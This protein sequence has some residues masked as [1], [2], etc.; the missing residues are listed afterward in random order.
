M[1]YPGEGHAWAD[2]LN[3]RARVMRD[4]QRDRGMTPAQIVQGLA[5]DETQVRLILM[6]VADNPKEFPEDP[7]PTKKRKAR[8]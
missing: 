8:P 5:M 3:A 2:F 4:W 6:H 1:G 7:Q